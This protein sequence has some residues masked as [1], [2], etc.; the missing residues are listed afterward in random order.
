PLPSGTVVLPSDGQAWTASSWPNAT[1]F[2]MQKFVAYASQYEALPDAFAFAVATSPAT[3]ANGLLRTP[4]DHY[5]APAQPDHLAIYAAQTRLDATWLGAP[6]TY[7]WQAS[8][9]DDD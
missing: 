9:V 3:D 7:Y 6:G 1:P 4:I 5:V 8:Y 2:Q